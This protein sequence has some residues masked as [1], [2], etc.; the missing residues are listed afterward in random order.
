MC[1]TVVHFDVMGFAIGYR[2]DIG[3]RRGMLV[4]GNIIMMSV[5]LMMNV[6]GDRLLRLG[7]ITGMVVMGDVL[8]RFAQRIG[9]IDGGRFGYRRM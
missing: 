5:V 2:M 9:D 8:G 7:F 4:M 6:F 3:G 1:F